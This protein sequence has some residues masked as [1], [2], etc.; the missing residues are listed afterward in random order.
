MFLL[1]DLIFL[2]IALFYLPVYLFQRK[3]HPGFTQ[4]IGFLP[5]RVLPEQPIWLHAVSVGELK[6]VQGLLAELRKAYPGKGFIISTVTPTAHQV[7]ERLIA[8]GDQLFYLP[9]DFSFIVNHVLE[10]IR[11]CLFVIAETE[12]WPN[13]ISCLH[14]RGIAVA[15]VNGR[16]S[17]SSFAGY[18]A[19]KFLLRPILEKI[20]LFCVQTERDRRRLEGLGAPSQRIKVSGNMKFDNLQDLFL[21]RDTQEFRRK[22]GLQDPDRLLVCGSTHPGEEELILSAYQELLSEFPWLRLLIAPRH[23]QRA[24]EIEKIISRKNFRPLRVSQ[25]RLSALTPQPMPTAFILDTIG[26]LDAYYALADMV[27]VGGSLVKKGGHNLLE[28]AGL[29]KPVIFGA[30]MFNFRDIADL[31]LGYN[32]GLMVH[33]SQELKQALRRL[34]TNESVRTELTRNARQLIAA[35]QGATARTVIW[36]KDLL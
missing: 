3:F 23:P 33:N 35:N 8:E 11:P 20:S 24:A 5:R 4:R 32:A 25:L 17:D 30:Q 15:E 19:V 21:K 9:L 7:A 26:E 10:K 16:I 22:L 28:P 27:F 34:L 6:A 14:K 2:I 13:L 31:F 1:Y 29:G 12:L 36:L 18:Q